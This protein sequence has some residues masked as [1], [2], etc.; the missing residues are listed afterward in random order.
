MKLYVILYEDLWLNTAKVSQ[1]G[2]KTLKEAQAYC[3]KCVGLDTHPH[4]LAVTVMGPG[5]DWVFIQNVTK[6][7]YTIVEVSV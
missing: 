5:D 4:N 3:R 1:E 6:Q 7:R 2:Y